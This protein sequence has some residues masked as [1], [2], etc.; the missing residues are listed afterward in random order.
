MRILEGINQGSP[1]W[2]AARATRMCA[3]EAP[4]M[5]G[6]SNHLTRADLLRLKTGGA[7][8]EVSFHQQVAFDAGHASEAGARAIAE[9]IIGGELYPCTAVSD[10]DLYLASFDGLTMLGDVVFEHKLISSALAAMIGFGELSDSYRWQV[11][12]QMMVSGAQKALFMASDG[13]PENHLEMWIER[14]D[15]RIAKL[16]AGWA[17]FQE[18]LATYV[19]PTHA[20]VTVG[21]APESLPALRIELTGMVTASNLDQFTAQAVAVFDGIKTDLA[22]DD[23]FA[24]AEKTVRWCK[25][26]EG[27]LDA[28][29][30]HALSQTASIDELFRAIDDIKERAGAKRLTLEKLVKSRKDDIRSDILKKASQELTIHHN[31]LRDRLGLSVAGFPSAF[32]DFAGAMKGKRTIASLHDAVDA[33]LVHAKIA[34]SATA[35]RMEANLKAMRGSAHASL[36]PD[37]EQLAIKE[38]ADVLAIMQGR[39]AQA[40]TEADRR[41]KEAAERAQKEPVVKPAAVITPDNTRSEKPI[42]ALFG[43]PTLIKPS[44][45]EII[46]LLSDHYRSDHDTVIGWMED[47]V[48]ARRLGMVSV[49]LTPP[50]T[51]L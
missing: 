15:A 9:K 51:A 46:R 10:D 34:A 12:H 42:P 40:Q 14:D 49:Q 13:T 35:D 25:D 38:P 17:Q 44:A 3:S 32:A 39:I 7:P 41:A 2:H 19:A 48:D 47:I 5:M 23:D 31:K 29:K 30:Q 6:V 37:A 1:E 20:P 18:D 11:D 50:P 27:R 24:N 16:I 4:A 45:I 36:F 33:V 26:I 8:A 21:V 43:A 28:A 22:T